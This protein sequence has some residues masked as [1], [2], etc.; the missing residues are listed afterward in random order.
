[1]RRRHSDAAPPSR[2]LFKDGSVGKS[3]EV[4]ESLQNAEHLDSL[5][6]GCIDPACRRDCNAVMR[7]A[8]KG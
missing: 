5:S 7:K 6:M 3:V 1:M 2:M 8:V 4:Q